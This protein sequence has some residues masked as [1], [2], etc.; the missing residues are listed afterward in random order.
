M[1]T[2]VYLE[3][4]NKHIVILQQTSSKLFKMVRFRLISQ[5]HCGEDISDNLFC[6]C[7]SDKHCSS[8]S[9]QLAQEY[10][11]IRQSHVSGF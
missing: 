7:Y 1:H 11:I 2:G 3:R 4:V 10:L 5:Y 8:E 6:L 9:H